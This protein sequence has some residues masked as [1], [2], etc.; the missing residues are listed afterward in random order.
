VLARI[1]AEASAQP[2]KQRA[3]E[4]LE[5]AW[6]AAAAKPPTWNRRTLLAKRKRPTDSPTKSLA[7]EARLGG[8]AA[9]IELGHYPGSAS[10][11]RIK[12]SVGRICGSPRKLSFD[13]EFDAR[14]R[15]LPA[16]KMRR[17]EIIA[18]ESRK[19]P[20]FTAQTAYHY[21]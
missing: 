21:F 6:D 5:R 16:P 8:R 7:F 13:D 4:W 17:L 12:T 2:K 10:P 18:E 20:L 15:E 9:R 3:E 19:F 1:T 14:I 11:L